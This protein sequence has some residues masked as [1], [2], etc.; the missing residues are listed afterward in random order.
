MPISFRCD[1]CGA[2]INAPEKA[3]GRQAKCPSCSAPVFVP[4]APVSVPPAPAPAAQAPEYKSCPYCSEQILA[5]AR[6]CK[7]CGE[8]LDPQLRA[9][10]NGPTGDDVVS[11]EPSAPL[12]PSTPA[13]LDFADGPASPTSRR[14]RGGNFGGIWVAVLLLILAA[15]GALFF[16]LRESGVDV[17]SGSAGS[18]ATRDTPAGLEA[19]RKE[20][21]QPDTVRPGGEKKLTEEQRIRW[22]KM[23]NLV[24]GRSNLLA[25]HAERKEWLIFNMMHRENGGRPWEP[26]FQFYAG[27][28]AGAGSKDVAENLAMSAAGD[29]QFDAAVLVDMASENDPVVLVWYHDDGKGAKKSDKPPRPEL[30]KSLREFLFRLQAGAG[31]ASKTN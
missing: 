3:A 18:P 11:T 4:Q 21:Q 20:V 7:H 8:L 12:L 30:A 29:P 1:G 22:D 15:G 28:Y 19:K 25:Y 27:I 10:R 6:K 2:A 31:D 23:R 24:R 16:I 14:D 13:S 9:E 26:R 5:A 17:G